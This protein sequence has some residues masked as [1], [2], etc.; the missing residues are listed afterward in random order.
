MTHQ[1]SFQ[2]EWPFDGPTNVATLT[3]RHVLD[4]RLPITLVAHD[5]EDGAWQM[6]C[7][8]TND[9]A[10]GRIECLGCL[11]ERDPSLAE[12]ADL[13]PGWV[14]WR[15]APDM[16]WHRELHQDPDGIGSPTTTS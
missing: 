16:P 12:I 6:L 13:P 4:G 14:A 3:T 7:G 5:L 15:E 2:K 9:P 8:T 11:F 10:D 1:H